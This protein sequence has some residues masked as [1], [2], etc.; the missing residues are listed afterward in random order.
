MRS[1]LLALPIAALLLAAILYGLARL[2]AGGAEVPP[3]PPG[4]QEIAWIHAATSGAQWER[5]V[6]GVHRARHDWPTDRPRLQ[7]DDSRAFLDQTTAVPEVV[8]GVEGSDA[9]LR[10][11]WYK[12]T[13]EAD[14]GR[15]VQRLAGRDSPPLAFI[16]GGT[17]DRALELARAL[18]DARGGWRGPDPLLLITTAT[19]NS[20]LVDP[21]AGEPPPGPASLTGETPLMDVYPQRSFRFCFTNRQMAEAVVDFLWSQPDLRPYGDPR[22]ALAAVPQAAADP[23]GAV[24]LAAVQA[25]ECAPEAAAVEWDDDPYSIDLSN[26]F[27]RAFHR[28][29]LPPVLVRLRWGIPFSVGDFYRTNAWEAYAA[30][31]LLRELRADPQQRRVL[32]LPGSVAPARRVL[33]A[34]TGAMPLAGQQLVAISG[35]SINVNTVY[36]DADF[37][38]SI[39]AV[40]VP[41]VFFTHQNPVAWDVDPDAGPSAAP[42][43][44]ADDPGRLLPPTATDDVLLPAELVRM[45]AES[46]YQ[47]DGTASAG[48]AAPPDLLDNANELA[49]RLRGRRPAFFDATGDRRGGRGEFVVVLRPVISGSGSSAQVLSAA[50]LDVWTRD[51]SA[52]GPAAPPAAR[53]AAWKWVK[54][55]RVPDHARS[56]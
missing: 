38:W 22:P 28:P 16:G 48:A 36:R 14:S 26:Q 37:A 2:R 10:I 5:F 6:A 15:W 32:V 46:A 50:T 39:R 55:L 41:L 8:L 54:G 30:R 17:T 35:D 27:R 13:S 44:A 34:I 12:L 56:P 52:A 51:E 45:L 21:A 3:V 11:R 25:G 43:T 24:A 19:A 1:R 33:R 4:D 31:E 49:A 29:G 23:W 47:F 9:K 20:V 53:A 18:A 7:V 40:P 42:G